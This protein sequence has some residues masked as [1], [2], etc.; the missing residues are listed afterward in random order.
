M[1]YHI[2]PTAVPT[3]FI[4]AALLM[5][6][7]ML[8]E[9][10]SLK[11]ETIRLP[12]APGAERQARDAAGKAAGL[13]GAPLA[14]DS[15]AAG[16]AAT[17]TVPLAGAPGEGS[18]ARD[19]AGETV[20]A[21]AAGLAGDPGAEASATAAPAATASAPGAAGAAASAMAALPATAA[22][23][24]TAATPGDGGLRILHISDVHL[25]LLRIPLRKITDAVR[26]TCPDIMVLT[27][28]YLESPK[29][30]EPFLA[31]LSEVIAAAGGVPCYMC[32]G[33]HDIRAF[34]Y[35]DFELAAYGRKLR[36]TG[37]TVLENGTASF[38]RGGKIYSITGLRDFS[39]KPVRAARAVRGA[40]KGAHCR[41][42]ITHNPDIA[43]ELPPNA[44]DLLMCGH[45]HGGQIWLPLNLQYTCLRKEK[46][47]R[48]G[49]CSGLH[50]LNG[51]K[52]Y[53]S[54]GI[55]CVLFPL[56]FRAKP[57][58]ALIIAP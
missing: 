44:L 6:W 57:E 39:H 9:A 24:A 14:G 19:A 40:I 38:A 20:G 56:R 21:A 47:C 49:I 37:A 17:G 11:L 12:G 51:I 8:R 53:I 29:D 10:V 22:P 45:F 7:L 26:E 32:F 18:Q 46:L 4:A 36:K 35:N 2:L 34:D 13:A 25:R 30:A 54:R 28:D 52:L 23:S 31:W 3:L 48:M 27:G 43:L 33:N 15:G 1:P 50:E 16:Q 41:I 5:L 55:G 58:I 42:G